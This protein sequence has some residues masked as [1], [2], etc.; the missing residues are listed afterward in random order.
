MV[1]IPLPRFFKK[2]RAIYAAEKHSSQWDENRSS[3]YVAEKHSQQL[4]FSLKIAPLWI[5]IYELA[6]VWNKLIALQVIHYILSDK[7][8]L[9]G[10][11]I[12]EEASCLICCGCTLYIC[13]QPDS[14]IRQHYL[15]NTL[16][17][18]HNS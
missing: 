16:T 15:S 11:I 12:R 7:H 2:G 3:K 4:E 8:V 6:H 1:S 10:N 9:S 18:A 14:F 5:P 13:R 17:T